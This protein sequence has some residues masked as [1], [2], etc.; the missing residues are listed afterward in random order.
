ME[1]D[2]RV[3]I[4]GLGGRGTG[5]LKD[6]LLE[7]GAKITAVCDLYEDRR[8][9]AAD[10]VEKS[11][12]PR[13]F[14]TADYRE[15]C[16]RS[17]VE[18]VVVTA[19]WEAHVPVACEAMEAGKFVG[20]EVGGAY[21]VEDCWRMV[22]T[23]EA[24]GTGFMFLENCCYG[25]NELLI[26]NMVRQGLFG[27]VV[28]C[29]GGY[30]HDLRDEIGFGRENRHYR[31]RNY[32]NRNGENYPTHELGPIAN[33][34]NINRGNRMVSLVS[35]ASR[36][37]GLHDYLLREKGPD[38]DASSFA[39]TQGDIVTTLIKC[40]HGETI[41]LSLDTTL[42]RY[43]SRGFTIHG[44]RALYTEDNNSIFLDSEDRE[45]HFNWRGKWDNLKEFYD[46]YDH[47]LW[48]EFQKKGVFG[49]HGGMDGL[50]Y[51]RFLEAAAGL[52][53]API[54]VYDA[55]AW[56]SITPLSEASIAA[57]S[58]PVAIPDFTGGAWTTR[59]PWNP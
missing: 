57:G 39:F 13:P 20:I 29:D 9:G 25:R 17:D 23:Y 42:P 45:L 38:Y 37:A 51:G 4:V 28:H 10:I 24:T 53:P 3:G 58:A 5:I 19:A 14:V 1:Q 16:A 22:R 59:E 50:V 55:A 18:A 41:R 34:L 21:S 52:R 47:P 11:G 35:M 15:L 12:Q 46:K 6:V 7:L 30:Q 2:V 49:G 26:L 36:T 56:M 40:A 31:F 8:E 48:K 32:L 27:E 44:T 54:D 33:I 43:Y